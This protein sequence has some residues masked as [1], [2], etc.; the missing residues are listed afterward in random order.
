MTTFKLDDEKS[1]EVLVEEF[2]YLAGFADAEQLIIAYES[3]CLR[4]STMFKI[5]NYYDS[6]Y[7]TSYIADVEK[8]LGR[9]MNPKGGW[10]D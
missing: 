4:E 7:G 6:E 10:V 9:K 5:C 1:M 2:L 3:N 8:I